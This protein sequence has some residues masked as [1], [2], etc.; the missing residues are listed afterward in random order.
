VT[1]GK[2]MSLEVTPD[3]ST[4]IDSSNP[5]PEVTTEATPA[6]EVA[7]GGAPA[8]AAPATSTVPAPSAYTPSFKY[9][10]RGQEKEIDEMFRALVK[11]ADSEKKV[12]ELFEKAEGL[13]F[14]KQ[15]RASLKTEYEGFKQQITPYLQEYHKFTS[16]R[17]KGNLGAALQVAGISDDQIFE[18][19][20]QRL[21]MEQ[22]PQQAQLYKSNN[23]AS[24]QM[25]EME[26][27]LQ[28]YQQMEQ[29]LQAQQF[30]F[31][32]S[33]AISAHKDVVGQIEQKWGAPGS[34]KEEVIA[35]GTA[36]F[37]MGKNLTEAQAVEAVLN[38]YKP[39]LST[40][41]PAAPAA[42]AQA[43]QRPSTI[44]N[45]GSTGLSVVSQKPKS[46]DDLKALAKAE[47]S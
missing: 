7:D 37:H 20:L 14:V 5:A 46:I 34:F 15:D 9:N 16:L 23:E 38:K 13:D 25:F 12:K 3:V 29:Q 19:A 18:Y 4:E 39:F 26:G 28:Q 31:N 43:H 45:V 17:D 27:K 1:K 8:V 35:F 30:D 44:P 21:Q 32:L 11:D 2:G 42:P 33:Q 22:N 24:L 36:Q 41:A 47:A 10:V 6:P 40:S